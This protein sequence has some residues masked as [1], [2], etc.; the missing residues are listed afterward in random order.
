ME[1]T[2]LASLILM[3]YKDDQPLVVVVDGLPI[4]LEWLNRCFVQVPSSANYKELKGLMSRDASVRADGPEG[5][6]SVS[7]HAK[8]PFGDQVRVLEHIDGHL[9]Q[10]DARRVS[11]V[12][13]GKM[14]LAINHFN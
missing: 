1:P 4:Q 5:F 3:A 11:M 9:H 12:T 2:H 8:V 6:V 7:A 10:I 14:G 13:R